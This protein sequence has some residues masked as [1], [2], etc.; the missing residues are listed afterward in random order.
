MC[1]Q[2]FEGWQSIIDRV[3]YIREFLRKLISDYDVLVT[4]F[5]IIHS[6]ILH[7]AKLLLQSSHT[8]IPKAGYTRA[9]VAAAG[10]IAATSWRQLSP[11]TTEERECI[12]IGLCVDGNTIVGLRHR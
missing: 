2:L 11:A 3:F 4:I 6:F 1:W 9:T 7:F 10:Y 8:T 5:Q 12:C